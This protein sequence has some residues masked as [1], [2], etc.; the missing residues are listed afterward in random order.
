MLKK[1]SDTN[2][3]TKSLVHALYDLGK[4]HKEL[5]NNKTVSYIKKMLMY[6]I[7]QKQGDFSGLQG[8]LDQM[9]SHLYGDHTGCDAALCGHHK[10]LQNCVYKSPKYRTQITSEVERL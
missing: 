9:I 1:L 7:L 2:H 6:A 10:D 8:C 3:T 4:K 5:K